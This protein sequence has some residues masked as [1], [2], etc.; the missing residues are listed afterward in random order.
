M[1]PITL[2]SR[3]APPSPYAAIWKKYAIFVVKTQL[4]RTQKFI[5]TAVK[6]SFEEA[7]ASLQHHRFIVNTT[8]KTSTQ[9]IVRVHSNDLAI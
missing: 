9:T 2:L 3:F 6:P 5:Q 4:N 1:I 7:L 8:P